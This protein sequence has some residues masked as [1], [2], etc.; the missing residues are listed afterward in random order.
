VR[1]PFE[2]GD[3][4]VEVVGT[5]CFSTI[6]KTSDRDK[7]MRYAEH[8]LRDIMDQPQPPGV[9]TMTLTEITS[10]DVTEPDADDTDLCPYCGGAKCVVCAPWLSDRPDYDPADPPPWDGPETAGALQ[11]GARERW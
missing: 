1:A 9:G 3:T 2:P 10:V 4:A 7:A 6:V 5:F 8:L 11:D